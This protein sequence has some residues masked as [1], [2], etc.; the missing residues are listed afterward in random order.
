MPTGFSA[1]PRRRSSSAMPG[2]SRVMTRAVPSGVWSRSETPVPPVVTS[3]LTPATISAVRARST[4]SAPSGTTTASAQ[5]NPASR[6]A[7]TAIGPLASSRS[8]AAE[9]SETVRTAARMVTAPA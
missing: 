2:T 9:R 4:L 1:A 3:S 5:S 6:S 7:A 8:P